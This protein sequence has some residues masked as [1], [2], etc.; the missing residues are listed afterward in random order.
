MAF[1]VREEIDCYGSVLT[2]NSK[3]DS[4]Y[5]LFCLRLTALVFFIQSA[6]QADCFRCFYKHCSCNSWRQHCS[7]D[8][9]H[10]EHI[11][12]GTYVDPLAPILYAGDLICSPS[13]KSLTQCNLNSM[14]NCHKPH[15]L[16]IS[17]DLSC[18]E[19]L[20]WI[21]LLRPLEGKTLFNQDMYVNKDG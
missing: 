7:N 1:K 11:A 13:I 3:N 16:V 12:F 5:F 2:I 8:V 19:C 14:P 21:F 6:K 18:E 9:K 4:V 17:F 20:G 10:N 15:W